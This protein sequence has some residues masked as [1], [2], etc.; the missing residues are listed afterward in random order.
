MSQTLRSI[1]GYAFYLTLLSYGLSMV[2]YWIS[3]SFKKQSIGV[4]AGILA[5]IGLAGNTA[6]VLL[7]MIISQRPPLTNGYEF[8]MAFGWGIVAIYLY[9]EFRYKFKALGA[10]V[11]PVAYLVL[12]FILIKMGSKGGSSSV[13]PALKSNWLIIHV[14]T[15]IL[16]Y[17]ALAV[18]F[19]IGIMYLIKDYKE[20]TGYIAC[21][22]IA[23][24]PPLKWLD[25]LAY[26]LN[27]FA[28][29]MLTICIVSGAIWADYV[30][31]TYWS[32]DPKETWSFI[33]WIIYACY[34]H[35]RLQ[36]GWKG[37]RAAW[38]NILGFLA[39]LFTFFGVN[40]FLTGSHIYI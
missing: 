5:I 9:I 6:A 26:K 4:L 8:L 25:E 40:Y 23:K 20:K 1:E 37:N 32:W 10:F 15:A 21:A 13:M 31:G 11:L 24:F 35:A 19:G 18:S 2:L 36:Y 16:A 38:I 30:W 14:L 34:F 27:G 12:V 39:V 3:L 22:W 33:T 28:F 7:R 29:S 17:G